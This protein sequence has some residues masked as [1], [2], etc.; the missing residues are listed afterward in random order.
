MRRAN[1]LAPTGCPNRQDHFICVKLSPLDTKTT[2]YYYSCS[3]AAAA[4]ELSVLLTP[5]NCN[6]NM[7][8]QLSSHVLRSACKKRITRSD[9]T[10][11]EKAVLLGTT[12]ALEAA[13]KGSEVSKR[14][15]C[16]KKDTPQM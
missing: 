16:W 10:D 8:Y 15:K 13:Y 6:A 2:L 3:H 1:R 5:L 7:L 9:S 11:Q 14:G 12:Q 4:L